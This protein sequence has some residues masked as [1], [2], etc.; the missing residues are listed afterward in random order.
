MRRFA[1][2]LAGSLL[3][4]VSCEQA[5][6]DRPGAATA[7]VS[8]AV[9]AGVSVAADTRTADERLCDLIGQ[10]VK[11]GLIVPE[12]GDFRQLQGIEWKAPIAEPTQTLKEV[13][14]ANEAAVQAEFDRRLPP[15]ERE[16]KVAKIRA[17]AEEHYAI[18]PLGT[19]MTLKRRK[20]RG[21][22]TELTGPL[23]EIG[24]D[25]VRIGSHFILRAD[26]DED[27]QARLFKDVHDR[28][29][30]QRAQVRI[31]AWQQ[32]LH[33]LRQDAEDAVLPDAF[34][35][36]GYAPNILVPG[37]KMDKAKPE[38][39]ISQAE[40]LAQLRAYAEELKTAVDAGQ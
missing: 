32:E 36:A 7:A 18:Y 2:I 39:W 19:K 27:E 11:A 29:V 6:K 33:Y 16:A 31:G 10:A 23:S 9:S 8:G 24:K 37:A 5:R 12:V 30:Q 14:A 26:I 20:G 40:L 21:T 13:V 34:R 25:R 22:Q 38:R 15:A 28:K 17:E 3:V 4:L 1:W 35:K